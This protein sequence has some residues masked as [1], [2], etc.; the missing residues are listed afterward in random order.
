MMCVPRVTNIVAQLVVDENAV[1]TGDAPIT[2][3]HDQYERA[4]ELQQCIAEDMN[5]AMAGV[6]GQ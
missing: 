1:D 3:V 2:A 6:A 5:V 4:R